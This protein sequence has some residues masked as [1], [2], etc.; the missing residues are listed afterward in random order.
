MP[1]LGQVDAVKQK[2]APHGL[3]VI[4]VRGEANLATPDGYQGLAPQ[5]EAA[6]KLGARF[7]FL[8][9]KHPG[10]T[11]EQACERLHKAG[12]LAKKYGIILVLETHPDLGTNGDEHV[13]TM[14][15]INHPNVRVN[16]DTGN[17][18]FYNQGLNAVDELKKGPSLP[19]HRGDQGP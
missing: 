10:A 3:K 7:M 16:F 6:R 8:S 14:K 15:R 1:P 9:P 18:T 2:F 5:L 13:R 12:N 17:I 19:G 11:K 4:V